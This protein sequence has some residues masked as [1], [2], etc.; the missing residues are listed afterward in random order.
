MVS[1][2][3]NV[4]LHRTIAFRLAFI[5]AIGGVPSF[6]GTPTSTRRRSTSAQPSTC[7]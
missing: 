7:W 1:L 3:Y 5:A 4:L 2:G 6:G